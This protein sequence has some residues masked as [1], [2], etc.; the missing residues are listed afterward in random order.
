MLDHANNIGIKD[1]TFCITTNNYSTYSDSSASLPLS[2]LHKFAAPNAILNS[3]GRAD[4]VR[5]HPGT[6]EEVIDLVEKSINAQ[7]DSLIAWTEG[8][9]WA[10]GG[11]LAWQL[12]DRAGRRLASGTNAGPVPVWGLVSAV[13]RPDGSFLVIH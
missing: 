12:R 8:T 10:R 1:S 4:E 3:G 11:S 7:G 9:A 13:T 5:C 2:L 6:R